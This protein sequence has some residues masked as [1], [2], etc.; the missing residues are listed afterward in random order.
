MR[1]NVTIHP[2]CCSDTFITLIG[3]L[4]SL[5]QLRLEL[6]LM[7]CIGS[8]ENPMI[9]IVIT[10]ASSYRDQTQDERST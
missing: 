1:H 10:A 4:I 9:I 3:P 2:F 7:F 5:D 8:L 6:E